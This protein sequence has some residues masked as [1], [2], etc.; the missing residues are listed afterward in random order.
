MAK[1]DPGLRVQLTLIGPAVNLKLIHAGQQVPVDFPF[2]ACIKCAN[3]S[4]HAIA[5]FFD[6]PLYAQRF[7]VDSDITLCHRLDAEAR[8]DMLT[9]GSAVTRQQSWIAVIL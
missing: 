9:P 2:S 7:V 3:D 1:T 5:S 6:L 8:F 4:A